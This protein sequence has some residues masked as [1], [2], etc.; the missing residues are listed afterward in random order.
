MMAPLS[1]TLRS[2]ASWSTGAAG[3]GHDGAA[4]C[5]AGM[6]H[7]KLAGKPRPARLVGGMMATEGCSVRMSQPTPCPALI[8]NYIP[9][10]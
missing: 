4:V 5:G 9:Y 6:A 3:Q 10:K 8:W 1:N 7:A 2:P